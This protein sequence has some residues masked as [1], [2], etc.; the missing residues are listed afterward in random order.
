VDPDFRFM[1][2]FSM[3]CNVRAYL[4][5]GT[6]NRCISWNRKLFGSKFSL[7]DMSEASVSICS[8]ISTTLHSLGLEEMSAAVTAKDQGSAHNNRPRRR[9]KEA[10]NVAVA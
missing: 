8:L 5:P 7:S 9:R 1:P 2:L 10:A 4:L 6:V 3:S